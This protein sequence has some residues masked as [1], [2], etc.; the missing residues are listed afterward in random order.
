MTTDRKTR[1]T[2]WMYDGAALDAL[3]E[4]ARRLVAIEARGRISA[5]TCVEA[6][7]TLALED[8]RRNGAQ[9]TW[10]KALVT[11]PRATD[12]APTLSES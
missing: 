1:H 2:I 8:L 10:L 4:E 5:S 6:A 12:T 7:V 3:R 11:L 9:S